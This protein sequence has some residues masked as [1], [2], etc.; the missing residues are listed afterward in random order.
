MTSRMKIKAFAKAA[1]K[2]ILDAAGKL[3]PAIPDVA[4]FE[5]DY[6]RSAAILDVPGRCQVQTYTCGVVGSWSILRSLGYGISLS[7][8]SKRC[9]RRGCNSDEG[10]D[11]DQIGRALRSL[12]LRVSTHR[13]RGQQQI[14]RF[15]DAGQPL[16][17]GQGNEAFSDGDHWLYL[18]GYSARYVYVGNVVKPLASKERW[19]WRTFESELN[20]REVYAI[21]T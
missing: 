1:V 19:G 10:M 20:P 4:S 11:I 6:P 13:Y 12:R 17:F 9:H 7:E 21:N 3:V 8:W 15:I 5:P 2:P 18:Y 16:L 14:R